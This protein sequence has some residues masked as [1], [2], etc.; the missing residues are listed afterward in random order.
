M[1]MQSENTGIK[2]QHVKATY[3]KTL[4]ALI[5]LFIPFAVTAQNEFIPVSSTVNWI[6]ITKSG[7]TD[8]YYDSN[9]VKQLG[10]SSKWTAIIRFNSGVTYSDGSSSGAYAWSEFIIDC[11]NEN[12]YIIPAQL[13]NMRGKYAYLLIPSEGTPI[14]KHVV[15]GQAAA[16]IEPLVCPKK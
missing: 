4:I 15:K 6:F 3:M 2:Y 5:L 8:I 14:V 9:S 13:T 16:E 10:N 12:F 7:L 1:N 11:S